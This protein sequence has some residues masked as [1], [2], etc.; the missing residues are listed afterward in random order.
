MLR[1][2]T[3]HLVHPSIRLSDCLSWQQHLFKLFV[4]NFRRTRRCY[5]E[6]FLCIRRV[7]H[8][9][10][11]MRFNHTEYIAWLCRIYIYLFIIYINL[12]AIFKKVAICGVGRL[13]L[14]INPEIIYDK[15]IADQHFGQNITNPLTVWRSQEP[16]SHLIRKQ[17][18][19]NRHDVKDSG[20]D[21]HRWIIATVF[22]FVPLWLISPSVHPRKE[23]SK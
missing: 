20:N 23:N 8:P 18:T 13:H 6:L 5:S 14:N 2:S 12:Y 21:A 9:F 11:Y 19:L 16:T 15:N 10:F 17:L 1:D 4:Y 22:K 7:N 3:P